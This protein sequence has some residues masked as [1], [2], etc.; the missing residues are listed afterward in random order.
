MQPRSHFRTTS[1]FL[2]PLVLT[3]VA[4]LMLASASMFVYLLTTQGL[5]S[6]EW[7]LSS[8]V[9]VVVTAVL[10][11]CLLSHHRIEIGE[12]TVRLIWFPLYVKTIPANQLRSV[13]SETVNPWH[14]GLGLRLLGGGTLG[15]INRGGPALSFHTESGAR[16]LIV[17][18]V[19]EERAEIIRR[20]STLI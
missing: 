15:L 2:S 14:T 5:S 17:V 4:L 8:V 3:L 7:I 6:G 10:T 11:G 9:L 18:P 20:I 1:T 13:A 19:E 12:D 16:Y